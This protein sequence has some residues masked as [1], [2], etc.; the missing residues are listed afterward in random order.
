MRKNEE[1]KLVDENGLTEEEFLSQYQPRDYERP[2][3]TVDMLIFA[4]DKSGENKRL[5]L[6]KRKNHPYLGCWALPG[7]FVEMKESLR[8]AAAREL[9]EE[10]GVKGMRLEQ[11]YTFG[12][13]ERD[14]RTRIISVAFMAVVDDEELSVR[15]GDDV[16]EAVWFRVWKEEGENGECIFLESAEA[17]VRFAYAVEKEAKG[18]GERRCRPIF[19]VEA[20]RGLAFDHIEAVRMGLERL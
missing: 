13:V 3:V 14:P 2:S 8:E 20:E 18:E 5:L 15:A 11:L 10:T 17:G 6:I 9:E 4:V 16:A 12:E 1:G 19:D 7:G